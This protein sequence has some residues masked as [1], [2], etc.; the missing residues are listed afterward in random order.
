MWPEVNP[1][2]KNRT[3]RQRGAERCRLNPHASVSLLAAPRIRQTVQSPACGQAASTSATAAKEEVDLPRRRPGAHERE[4]SYIAGT[5]PPMRRMAI[6]AL[7]E[8]YLEATMDVREAV[9]SAKQHLLEIFNSEPISYVGLE[10]I[11]F[12]DEAQEWIITVSFSRLWERTTVPASMRETPPEDRH[13]KVFRMSD[14]DGRVKSV[15]DR[16]LT[17]AE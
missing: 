5:V 16:V 14:S 8:R 2:L 3:L 4:S 15:K 11:E 6:M 13:F 10:E 17:T 1:W 7:C 12:D 9:Q